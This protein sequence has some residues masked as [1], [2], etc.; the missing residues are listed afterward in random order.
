[1]LTR[2][3]NGSSA[4]V[5]LFNTANRGESLG[6]QKTGACDE[7]RTFGF[8]SWLLVAVTWAYHRL[9]KGRDEPRLPAL[10]LRRICFKAIR[11]GRTYYLQLQLF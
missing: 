4:R 7:D 3:N 11:Y 8:Y 10:M 6:I 1:M 5:R 9:P 2:G